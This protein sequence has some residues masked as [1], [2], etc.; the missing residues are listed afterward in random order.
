M[1]SNEMLPSLDFDTQ[2]K[3]L[4]DADLQIEADNMFNIYM[5]SLRDFFLAQ[6]MKQLSL[7]NITL[8][9]C[10]LQKSLV[11]KNCRVAMKATL[12]KNAPSSWNTEVVFCIL[13]LM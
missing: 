6:F 9:N 11:I 13:F 5:S 3:Y 10:E 8:E 4:L 12:P 2:I 7:T 1:I